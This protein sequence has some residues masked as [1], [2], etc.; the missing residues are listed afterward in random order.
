[1]VVLC[2]AHFSGESPPTNP[3]RCAY[4]TEVR[5]GPWRNNK[6]L[7]T[8]KIVARVVKVSNPSAARNVN[9]SS[10]LRMDSLNVF[11]GSETNISISAL[12]IRDDPVNSAALLQR[13]KL[14][15]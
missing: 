4:P 14:N 1:M 2:V 13:S 11:D 7:F 9:T 15:G 5:I 10:R 3:P 12:D 6:R 8:Q